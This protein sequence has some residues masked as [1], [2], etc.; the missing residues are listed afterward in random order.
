MEPELSSCT[1]SAGSIFRADSFKQRDA[2]L[3]PDDPLRAAAA[4]IRQADALLFATGAGM[5]VDSGLGTYRGTNA[6]NFGVDYEEI[7]QPR[8]FEE[9]PEGSP[10]LAWGF[11]SR[12]FHAYKDSTPHAGYELLC[13]WGKR[14]SNG[15]FSLTSNVDGHWLRSG[16]GEDSVWE[17]HGS[18]HHLQDCRYSRFRANERCEV[19][20]EDVWTADPAVMAAMTPPAWWENDLFSQISYETRSFT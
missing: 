12:C 9:S 1:S 4:A 5:G 18:V 3:P 17:V 2:P 7:C 15:C 10:E 8:W 16:I 20:S 13:R 6:G 11:W 14:A 19:F